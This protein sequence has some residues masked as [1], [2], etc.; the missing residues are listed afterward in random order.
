LTGVRFPTGT[1]TTGKMRVII[2]TVSSTATGTEQVVC[3]LSDGID[4]TPITY[5]SPN[6]IQRCTL[7]AS[8]SGTGIV[9]GIYL[10]SGARNRFAVRDIV[11]NATGTNAIGVDCS[12]ADTNSQVDLKTSTIGGQLYDILQPSGLGNG[13]SMILI[14]ATDLR[15]TNANGY[16]FD[17]SIQPSVLTFTLA[18]EVNFSGQGGQNAT[19]LGKYYIV[20]GSIIANF[21]TGVVGIPI[22]RRCIIFQGSATASTS[23]TTGQQVVVK[24]YTS[25]S[26]NVLGTSVLTP[27]TITPST[28]N[29]TFKNLSYTFNTNDFIQIECDVNGTVPL[30]AGTNIFVNLLVY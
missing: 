22:T 5:S 29:P 7:N 3:V 12:L 30:T 21:A 20:P 19:P 13:S 4:S 23:L 25:T 10:P 15:N 16:G 27:L 18:S 2:M 28:L 8:S 6:P 24:I 26:S 17:V 9:R 14:G 11:V 1:A